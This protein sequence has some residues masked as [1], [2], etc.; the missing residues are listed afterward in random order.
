[1]LGIR[2][3]I[4]HSGKRS[5]LHNITKILQ[6]PHRRCFEDGGARYEI[7]E[8]RDFKD[9]LEPYRIFGWGKLLM[10]LSAYFG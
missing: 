2:K 7:A 3:D 10:F 9:Q 1:M 6:D 8:L 4:W 5:R